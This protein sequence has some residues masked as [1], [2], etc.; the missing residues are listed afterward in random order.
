MPVL[1]VSTVESD[2]R[3]LLRKRVTAAGGRIVRR[4]SNAR[5]IVIPY[6]PEESVLAALQQIKSVEDGSASVVKPHWVLR[7]FF[8]GYADTHTARPRWE[9]IRV[10]VAD[11]GDEEL[12]LDVMISLEREGALLVPFNDCRVCV[13]P[14]G[15]PYLSTRPTAYEHMR[16]CDAAYVFEQCGVQRIIPKLRPAGRSEYRQQ[17]LSPTLASKGGPGRQRDIVSSST[18]AVSSIHLRTKFTAEDRDRLA[19]YLAIACPDE[20]GR[21][22]RKLYRLLVERG[23]N[24]QGNRW[25]WTARHPA[26]GWRQHYRTY[27]A[28]PWHDG[29]VLEDLIRQYVEDGI[30]SGF[31]TTAERRTRGVKTP[32][33]RA[34]R[35][36][37]MQSA[38]AASTKRKR[39]ERQVQ[40]EK[41]P[42]RGVTKK[43]SKP[44]AA[45]SSAS[46]DEEIDGLLRE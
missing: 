43:R 32:T 42:Y 15:H 29:T 38:L 14:A 27:K 5:I 13:L 19:R 23:S 34:K 40:E 17:R 1:V 36:A 8:D 25:S 33:K 18:T 45:S 26:E 44:Q 20:T 12:R 11:L 24:R 9:N 30:D 41:Q 21:T 31:L 28:R 46:E 6:E 2:L 39:G 16:F 3:Q 35:G 7:T 37:E 4:F 22:S 10:S